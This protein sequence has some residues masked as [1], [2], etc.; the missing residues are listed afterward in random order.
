MTLFG[1]AKLTTITLLFW[2]LGPAIL[3]R[4]DVP[5]WPSLQ[6]PPSCVQR[7]CIRIGT[8]NIKHFGRPST[9]HSD[10]EQDALLDLIAN[11]VEFDVVVLTEIDITSSIWRISFLPKLRD[12]GYEIAI[13]GRHGGRRSQYI[14][15]IFKE[16]S[17]NHDPSKNSEIKTGLSFG[18]DGSDC[19]YD[20]LREPVVSSFRADSFDFVVVGVHLKSQINQ[21][22]M[23]DDCDDDIR[24][25]QSGK[26]AEKIE[27][28]AINLG[29]SDVIVVGDFNAPHDDKSLRS[30]TG[31]NSKYVAQTKYRSPSSGSNSYV[32]FAN[33][34][35]RL[36]DHVMIDPSATTAQERVNFSTVVLP[37]EDSQRSKY[38]GSISDHVPVWTYFYTDRDD[39]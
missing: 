32:G 35:K 13:K 29:E 2:L 38:V 7:N 27:N 24:H 6:Q 30:F 14:V 21:D 17:I 8:F 39:D 31:S 28:L 34:N 4:A 25:F 15:T 18:V 9:A 37:L 36:I 20:G 26:I 23:R 3:V 10:A 19:F 16:Q 11:I 22:S 33:V 1:S 5:N 12:A